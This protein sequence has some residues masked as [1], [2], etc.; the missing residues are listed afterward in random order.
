MVTFDL[1]IKRPGSWLRLAGRRLGPS[2]RYV[3]TTEVH[4]YAFSI[5]ANV[6]LSFFPF[7]VTLLSVCRRWLHWQGA[8]EVILGLLRIRLPAGTESVVKNL[9]ALA[10]GR[11]RLQV[12]SV[13]MLLFT[14]SGVFLPLEVALNKIWGF[15]RNRS[16][17]RNLAA[18]FLLAFISGVLALF[19]IVLTTALQTLLVL[20]FNWVPAEWFLSAVSRGLFEVVSIPFA[21]SIFFVI[22][23]YLPNGR[24]PVARVLPAAVIAGTLVTAAKFVYVLTLPL[25]RFREVYG[26]FALSA[27]L[28]FWA[29]VGALIM[30]FGAHLSVQGFWDDIWEQWSRRQARRSVGELNVDRDSATTPDYSSSAPRD[31]REGPARV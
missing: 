18:S 7:A 25:F 11:P 4:A 6:Y 2:L 14:T 19:W 12:M 10:L 17:L 9:A 28:L 29:F 24:V 30:L 13:F 8:Y 22:Y 31:D 20:L 21:I 3:F 5:A 1:G 16:F 15:E 26:P 27:T 23:Y